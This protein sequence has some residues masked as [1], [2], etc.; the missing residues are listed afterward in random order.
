MTKRR[1]F[2]SFDPRNDL[3]YSRMVE[4][5]AAGSNIDLVFSIEPPAEIDENSIRE[6]DKETISRI[7]SADCTLVIVGKEANRPHRHSRLIGFRNWMNFEIHHSKRNGKKI[8]AVKIDEIYEL[9][10]ELIRTGAA[11]STRFT[12]QDVLKLLTEGG[13]L[14]HEAVQGRRATENVS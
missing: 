9:P 11:W 2:V 1:V 8:M 5:W 14:E 6:I 10:D 7:K 3:S 12:A 13:P 4:E